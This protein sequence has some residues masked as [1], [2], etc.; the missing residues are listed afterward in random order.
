M[1]KLKQLSQVPTLQKE[2]RFDIARCRLQVLNA[3]RKKSRKYHTERKTTISFKSIDTGEK[4]PAERGD[5]ENP[6][7]SPHA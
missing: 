2:S 3:Q 6:V 4:D 5:G 7:P 1:A